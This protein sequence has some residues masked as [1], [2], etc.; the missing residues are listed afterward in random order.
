MFHNRMLLSIFCLKHCGQQKIDL[1]SA[2]KQ[3]CAALSDFLHFFEASSEVDP[4]NMTKCQVHCCTSPLLR[5]RAFPPRHHG[6][7]SRHRRITGPCTLP[8]GDISCACCRIEVPGG[9][10]IYYEGDTRFTAVC[11]N[12]MHGSCVL[13][14]YGSIRSKMKGRP[15]AM[16]AAWLA[17]GPI[18]E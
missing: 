5:V 18:T 8:A 13:T 12:P 17:A 16:M 7:R 2:E 3:N 1:K 9:Q 10:L 4:L 15:C 11:D 14:R 6:A